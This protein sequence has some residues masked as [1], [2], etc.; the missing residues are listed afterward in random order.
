MAD[1]KEIETE[2]ITKGT[3]YRKLADK[4]GLDQATIARMGKKEDW[5]SKRK[6]HVSETQAKVLAADTKQK[7]SRAEKLN[8]AADLLLE[9]VVALVGNGDPLDMDTQG[10]KHISGVLKD[11]KEIYMVKSQKDLEEQDA[12]IAKLRREAEKDNSKEKQTITITL[13]GGLDEYAQ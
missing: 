1:W 2:Y 9:R 5:V 4:Y 7:V 6:H 10:M 11:L 8:K 13:E 12:R 3:S